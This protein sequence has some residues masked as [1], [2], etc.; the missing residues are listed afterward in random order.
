MIGAFLSKFDLVFRPLFPVF[1]GFLLV[2]F[3]ALA[4]P[5]P[6]VGSIEPSL[7]IAAVYYWAIYRPDL[8]RPFAVFFLGIL[9]DIIHFLPLG[10]SSILFISVYQLALSQRRYF[11]KQIF[12]MLWVGF[13]VIVFLAAFASWCAMSLYEHTFLPVTPV[14]MQ[15]T[16]SLAIFP[17]PAWILI[18]IQR[19]FLSQE[20]PNVP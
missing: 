20:S 5:F 19:T 16:I 15:S 8:L 4:L 9:N 6:Y 11:I 17:I 14:L 7:G 12:F 2:L 1:T 13:G 10:L 18:K 3:S